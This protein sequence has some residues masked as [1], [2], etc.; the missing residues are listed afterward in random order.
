MITII[1]RSFVVKFIMIFVLF[2]FILP[3][4]NSSIDVYSFKFIFLDAGF[5]AFL[6]SLIT[7]K[8]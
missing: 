2:W 7:L 5:S 1:A 3:I 4:L 6:T 8:R